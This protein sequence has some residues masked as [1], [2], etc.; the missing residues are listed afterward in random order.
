MEFVALSHRAPEGWVC[1]TNFIGGATDPEAIKLSD[2]ELMQVV[3][4]DL[5]KVL[6]VTGE[7]R[8]LPI[9]RH[10]APIPQ[11]VIGHARVSPKLKPRWII[12]RGCGWQGTICTASR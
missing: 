12:G 1:L 10:D 9:T 8:R 11:Y 4:G 3:H 2:E 7:P 6:G 5:K